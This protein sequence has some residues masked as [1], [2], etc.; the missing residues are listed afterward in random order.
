MRY[1]IE[2][3]WAG[4]NYSAHAPDVL[5]CAATGATENECRR[6]MAEALAFHL[7]GLMEDGLP[8]PQPTTPPPAG[9]DLVEV[10]VQA[11]PVP[12]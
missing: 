11:V 2:I 1:R 8:I 12:T 3:A 9:T 7:E 10:S 4:T 6:N 5:G